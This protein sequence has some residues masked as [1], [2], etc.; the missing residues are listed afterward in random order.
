[1][2]FGFALT[3]APTFTLYGDGTF[4]LRPIEDPD[5]TEFSQGFPRFLQ[6]RMT[7]EYVQALLGLALGPGRLL[8]ARDHYP[9]N[10]CADC[11]STIFT[12]N[13][14]GVAK[15]V[16]VDALGMTDEIGPDAAHRRGF[17]QLAQTI[18]DLE[19]RARSGELGDVVL[20]DPELYRVILFEAFGDP[21]E[22]PLEWPWSDVTLNDFEA[23]GEFDPPSLVMTREN[24]AM[25][26]EVPSGGHLGVWV[27]DSDG[28]MWQLGV[29]PLLP[30]EV[31]SD[32]PAEG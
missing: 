20:Y 6:G 12:I 5:R 10:T 15:T 2:I 23:T 21:V 9:Q 14:G 11:G 32:L 18:T 13:A 1:M 27:E 24:V 4:L 28:R 17:A 30:D 31:A 29:R 25:L 8:D 7:E 22:A 26:L 16:T 19:A 3:Q